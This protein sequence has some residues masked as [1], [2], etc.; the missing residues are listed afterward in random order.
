[1]MINRAAISEEVVEEV[2]QQQEPVQDEE[3][4]LEEITNEEVKR[5]VEELEE[6]IDK[7]LEHQEIG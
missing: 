3:P 1:M 5:K 7:L 4:V 2:P 6:Q